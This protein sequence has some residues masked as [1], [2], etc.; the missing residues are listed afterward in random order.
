MA[1][2]GWIKMH[3]KI[4][5]CWIWNIDK[6]FDERSAWIDL[7][8]SANHKD[9]KILFNGELI[10]VKR[11]EF[12]T[13]IR[14]LSDKWKWNKDRVLKFLKLLE[15]DGMI[16]KS[17]DR[18]RTLITIDNYCIYQAKEDEIQTPQGTPDG[19]LYGQESATNKNDKNDKNINMLISNDINRQTEVRQ[20]VEEWNK[21]SVLGIKS[22]S[23][24][25]S[26]SKRYAY[27]VARIKQFG[28]DD[29]LKAID[30]I[31]HSDFLQGKHSGKPWQITFDWFV[32]PSN[33][34]KVLEGNYDNKGEQQTFDENKFSKMNNDNGRQ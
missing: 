25:D 17:S 11:G 30:N 5:D 22:V 2:D 7:L 6:P 14:K 26:S 4:Q 23:K 16:T 32:L 28:I 19:T 3:R 8:L 1:N 21:L 33:F 27:L 15:S 10:L 13:S 34:P 20:V 31:R 24:I 9:T 29:I 12:V 18:Y